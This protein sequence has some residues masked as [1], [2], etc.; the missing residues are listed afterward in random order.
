MEFPDDRLQYVFHQRSDLI[1]SHL[2]S[3]QLC[4]IRREPDMFRHDP[5]FHIEIIS[6]PI[7]SS[8]CCASCRQHPIDS[9]H[10]WRRHVRETPDAGQLDSLLRTKLTQVNVHTKIHRNQYT[11]SEIPILSLQWHPPKLIILPMIAQWWW[12]RQDNVTYIGFGLW[13][14]IKSRHMSIGH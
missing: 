9:D 5:S 2:K 8:T 12:I 3:L 14:F 10:G 1:H 4:T 7:S 6:K 13:C 11:L